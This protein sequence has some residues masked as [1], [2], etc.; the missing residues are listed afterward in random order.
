MKIRRVVN[1]KFWGFTLVIVMIVLIVS[2]LIYNYLANQK[3]KEVSLESSRYVANNIDNDFDELIYMTDYLAVNSAVQKRAFTSY[4]TYN[5]YQM[6]LDNSEVVSLFTTLGVFNIVEKLSNIYISNGSQPFVYKLGMQGIQNTEVIEELDYESVG[7]LTYWQY[8]MSPIDRVKSTPV[9]QFLRKIV[10]SSGD[11]ETILYFEL[12]S[13]YLQESLN[14]DSEEQITDYTIIDENNCIL[15]N[16]D[17]ELLGTIYEEDFEESGYIY[18]EIA[19]QNFGWVL[20][21]KTIKPNIWDQEPLVM[22]VIFLTICMIVLIALKVYR[23]LDETIIEPIVQL[24]D[25]MQRVRKEDF[26][27]RITRNT[28]GEMGQLVDD[29]NETVVRLKHNMEAEVESVKKIKDAEYSMLQAQINPHFISNSLNAAKYIASINKQDNL[30]EMIQNIW[31]LMRNATTTDGSDTELG[32]EIEVIKA[33]THLEEVRYKGK[34]VVE[35]DIPEEHLS[36]RIPKYIL[37]PIVENAIFHG[38]AP[39]KGLGLIT[40]RSRIEDSIWHLSVIDD[41]IGMTEERKELILREGIEDITGLSSV[42]MN[43]VIERM[44][45]LFKEE[46]VITIESEE[47]V[48]TTMTLHFSTELM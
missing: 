21:S 20:I 40:I 31:V 24:S 15:Y 45:I 35:Y 11:G 46:D 14:I 28:Q 36:K 41:G 34:F 27:V 18:N 19:L 17:I 33:Y 12:N 48:G 22:G 39:K 16:E 6:L 1:E 3:Y 23:M 9:L 26:D 47:G 30:V 5:Q 42:G 38:V 7:R 8:E 2:S 25:G 37:Q 10:N 13:S 43:N 29:F 4:G 32:K 44:R